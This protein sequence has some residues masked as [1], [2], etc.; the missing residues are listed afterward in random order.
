MFFEKLKTFLE[1]RINIKN[2]NL[3]NLNIN[4][5][6]NPQKEAVVIDHSKSTCHINLDKLKDE[7]IKKLREITKDYIQEDN[8]L[9]EENALDL[10]LELY[11]F[12]KSSN[13]ALEFFQGIIPPKDFQTLRAAMFI[14]Q[15][16]KKGQP[17][18]DLKRDIIM[19]FGDRGKNIC[20]LTTAG[21]FEEFLIPLYNSDNKET[22]DEI[23][24]DLVESSMLAIFVNSGMYAKDIPGEIKRK[25]NISKKYGFKFIHIH[26]IGQRN[27]DTIY[28]FIEENK[29]TGLFNVEKIRYSNPKE[30][31]LIAELILT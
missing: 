6:R 7:E 17:I 16:F 23:Y 5:E 31:I 2:N 27:I 13:I 28:Q 29:E 8:I 14:R 19:R 24:N 15:K 18:S 10:L 1:T 9:L 4:I 21:Y 22:F 25:I 30:H 26:G 3:I 11:Q 12:K 20:N